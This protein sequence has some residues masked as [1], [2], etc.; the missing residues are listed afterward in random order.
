MLKEGK[1]LLGK[2]NEKD[3]FIVP[4][5][6][7]RHG[8][9]TG[10]SGTGKTVTAKVIAEA[11]SELGV[12]S[13]IADVKGDLTGMMNK[14]NQEGING[15][16]ESMGITDYEVRS[17]PVHFFDIYREY[18]APIRASIQEMGPLLISR[19]LD[20]TDAQQGILNIIFKVAEEMELEIIDLKDLQAMASYVGEHAKEYTLKYG[21]VSKQSVGAIQ[22]KLLELEDQ[23]GANF[24]GMPELDIN[25]FMDKQ[26]GLGYMNIIECSKLFHHPLLYSTF[27]Y[28]M[29]EEIYKALP[30]VGDLDQPK[31]V[32]FFDEAHLLFN[33]A[34]RQLMEKIEQ[35]VKLIR[36]KGV[37]VFFISQSPGD[38]P[39]SV[40]AQLSNRIQHSLRAY[41]PA[42]IKVC[43][44]AAESFRENPELNVVELISNMKTGTALVSCLQE[45]G[46]PAIVEQT[47]ILPPKSSMEIADLTMVTN[48]ARTDSALVEY[49]S[50]VDP[51]SAYESIDDI[52][53]Q[54][55]QEKLQEEEAKRLAKEQERLEKQKAKEKTFNERL[56][57]KA[58]NKLQTELVNMFAKTAKKAIKNWLK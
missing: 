33:N 45:D 47:K 17:F 12:P 57:R 48:Y 41:T 24:F 31:L 13:V 50:D 32:F 2:A 52:R 43:K 1:I 51:M 26:D 20:L 44:M 19:I 49:W 16:L 3:V 54:D 34:N 37:G 4:S 15:R 21:N 35:T 42:E 8:L 6:M 25:T 5:Q 14:G 10:A 29:L 9:I 58:S 36:S 23:G 7:N 18:G 55:E 22:R 40:L 39:N 38:I 56:A 11:L 30:E 28:W 46:S 53:Y 27:L